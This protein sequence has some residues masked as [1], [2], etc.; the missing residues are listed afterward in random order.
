L[1]RLGRYWTLWRTLAPDERRMRAGRLL[2]RLLRQRPAVRRL[3]LAPDPPRRRQFERALRVPVEQLA[4][5]LRESRRERGPLFVDL[6][7]RAADVAEAHPAHVRSVLD[8]AARILEGRIDLLGSGESRPVRADGGLDWHRDWKSGLDWPADVFHTDLAVVRGDGSDVKLPWELSRCQHLLVLGQAYLL[9]PHAMAAADAQ[10]LRERCAATVQARIDDWTRCNPR[11]VGVNWTCTMEVAIRAAT[12]LA[13]LGLLRSAPELDDAFFARV[14]RGLWMHGRHIRRHLEIGAD[15][16]TSNHYLA[17]VVGLYTLA[18]GL[19]ELREAGAWE[20]LSRRALEE[21]IERQVLPDGV[22]FERSLSY[23]RLVAE[24]FLHAALLAHGRGSGFSSDYLDKLARMLE[25]TATATRGDHT[26]PQW[27]DNDDGRWLPLDGYASAEPHDHRHLLV[28]GGRFLGR[29]DLVAAGGNAEV[30][31]LWLLGPPRGSAVVSPAG[32]AS[33]AFP[34]AGY[35]VMRDGDLHCGVSCGRVGTCGVGNHSH[36]DVLSIC[37]W[38]KGTEWIT[39]P[40]TG[41]YTSDPGLRNRLRS[42]S[43]HATLQLGCREQNT[44]GEGLDGLFR[45]HERARPEVTS[46]RADAEGVGLEARHH[47][48]GA[49]GERWVHTRSIDFAP[50]SRWW[51]IRDLLTREAGD[52][53]PDEQVRLRFPLRPE[54]AY[55]IVGAGPQPLERLL[56][57]TGAGLPRDG[58]RS[59]LAVRL[60]SGG[61]AAFWIALDLPAGSRVGIEEGLYSPRYGVTQPGAV[62]TATLPAAERTLALSALWSPETS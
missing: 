59:R 2:E 43:A 55:E 6:V 27:G 62:V 37:V 38:T 21:E 42:T 58:A 30:E 11:G 51:L 22:D 46:W 47:G 44:F 54:V 28:L 14:V 36:N 32:H 15:G 35:Y 18:C 56:K 34:D 57:A 8:T 41:V 24:M 12:W 50:R 60:S 53:P 25:F 40:G 26:V 33:R 3:N 31:A 23:H 49:G 16:L 10:R 45:L 17:D 5:G 52:R 7:P 13:V 29:D 4:K 19:P 1:N 20:R 39:D 61:A 9:A 48:F